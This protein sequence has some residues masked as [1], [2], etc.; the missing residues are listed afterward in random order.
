[1]KNIRFIIF[2][3]ILLSVSCNLKVKV[4]FPKNYNE[5]QQTIKEK[6]FSK[7]LELLDSESISKKQKTDWYYYDYALALYKINPMNVRQA[8]SYLMNAYYFN[9][10]SYEINYLLGKF[11]FEMADYKKAAKYFSQCSNLNRNEKYFFDEI[12]SWSFYYDVIN[13]LYLS[14]NSKSKVNPDNSIIKEIWDKEISLDYIFSTNDLSIT[15]KILL[16]ECYL[17]IKCNMIPPDF[18]TEEFYKNDL[19]D[20]VLCDYIAAKLIYKSIVEKNDKVLNDILNKYNTNDF[21]L[22][23]SEL[24]YVNEKFYK[25]LSFYYWKEEDGI[26]ANNSLHIYDKYHSKPKIQNDKLEWELEN[27]CKKFSKDNEFILISGN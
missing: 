15:G 11:N 13:C 25:Y 9:K 5:I 19:T 21:V 23:N 14:N 4:E 18:F 2:S 27:I 10:K 3:Y 16:C 7:T 12:E 20:K 17:K 22:M 26:K 8:C 24:P 1:M 6:N